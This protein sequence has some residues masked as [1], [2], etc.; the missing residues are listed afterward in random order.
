MSAAPPEIGCA[1]L[2]IDEALRLFEQG[3]LDAL[4]LPTAIRA[5][6][7]IRQ[8][9]PPRFYARQARL[10]TQVQRA[11]DGAMTAVGAGGAAEGGVPV[12]VPLD[13]S[14]PLQP[15]PS[16]IRGIL[17]AD[18]VGM[19]WG[20]PGSF[21]S[22]LALD[23][24]LSVASG[25]DW[26]GHAAKHRV[27]WYLAGEG[28]AALRHRVAAWRQ[29]RNYSGPVRLMHS[30]RAVLLD[31]DDAERSPGLV[32]LLGL[33]QAGGA[34]DLIVV[35]TLARSMVGDESATRDA[36][37]FVAALDEL[38]AETRR[39]GRAC[40]V[41][42]VHHSR[43]DGNV[44]RGSS[45]LRG[46]S[47]FEYEM[48]TTGFV[49]RLECHKVK[50]SAKPPTIHLRASVEALGEA[51]DDFGQKVTMTSLV[52]WPEVPA[53]RDM[54]SIGDRARALLPSILAALAQFPDGASQR[55]LQDALH[56]AKVRFDK[57]LLRGIVEFLAQDG[58]LQVERSTRG[59]LCI[60]PV[61]K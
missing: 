31:S 4:F 57:N 29:A 32:Q 12:L 18:A 13:E 16:L 1:D 27:V 23:W 51:V 15:L 36:S 26:L 41:V 40:T 50:D 35:D 45:V 43:K 54:S 19:L 55:G 42:L 53:V 6:G 24:A 61:Q 38:V 11:L 47:D 59:A 10:P 5:F 22:F 44:Y 58:A 3:E 34:P 60:K 14:K 49:S 48:A 2:M 8:A 52:L 28:H 21:K 46:A 7:A 37:R 39:A 20:E 30:R 17:P 25:L 56:S 9:D 33:I